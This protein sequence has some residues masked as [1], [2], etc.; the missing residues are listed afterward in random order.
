MN[1]KTSVIIEAPREKVWQF[2]SN[3]KNTI[4]WQPNF[5]KH[6]HLTGEKGADGSTYKQYYQ[7]KGRKII[8]IETIV[9]RRQ[10]EYV[11]IKL[12]SKGMMTSKVKNTLT[13]LDNGSCELVC[14]V[15]T[16]FH[17]ALMSFLS[18]FMKKNFIKRQNHHFSLLKK[19]VENEI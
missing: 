18:P 11:E 17:N 6:E 2:M 16:N 12:D 1:Y 4:R 9:T 5:V 15:N 8:I 19:E 10:P 3:P 14:Q 7:E 13:E